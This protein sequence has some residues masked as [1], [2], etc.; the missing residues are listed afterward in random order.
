MRVERHDE[1]IL[2]AT[3]ATGRHGII[4]WDVDGGVE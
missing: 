2:A 4:D 3:D 1:C